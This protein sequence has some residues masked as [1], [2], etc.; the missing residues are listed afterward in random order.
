MPRIRKPH[1][2]DP[3]HRY[4]A[5]SEGD[6]PPETPREAALCELLGSAPAPLGPEAQAV[7][8]AVGAAL[9]SFDD[10]R[11]RQLFDACLLAKAAPEEL[12]SVFGVSIEEAGAYAELFFDRTVFLNDFHAIAYVSSVADPG[13]R[14]LLEEAF[15]KG[16][17]AL[18]AK[19]ASTP[20]LS[21]EAALEQIFRADAQQYLRER[22][23][24][25]GH[26]AGKELRA[27]HKS[28]M[29][30]ATALDKV[31]GPSEDARDLEVTF[32]IESGPPNPALEELLSKGVSIA[33]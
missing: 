13:E 6:R 10:P 20:D 32:V 30:T 29:A 15:S 11:V 26:K 12:Q 1:S 22:D 21:A 33:Q 28:V 23:V 24:P 18:R 27:L 3:R 14:K 31:S 4:T 7:L 16:F 17:S 9:C 25:V 2:R 8:P 5:I 19:Y